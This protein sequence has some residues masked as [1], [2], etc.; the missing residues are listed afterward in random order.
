MANGVDGERYRRQHEQ[1]CRERG[2]FGERRGRAAGTKGGLA[3]LSAEGCR[4]VSGLTALQKNDNDEEQANHYVDDGD[5]D[6]H[7]SRNPKFSE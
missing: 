3:A 7:G 6:D 2:G 1:H 4:N 5:K